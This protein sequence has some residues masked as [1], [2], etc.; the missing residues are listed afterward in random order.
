[1]SRLKVGLIW[2]MC[3]L[4]ANAAYGQMTV[5]VTDIS[6]NQSNLPGSA[7]NPNVNGASG[8]RVNSLGIDR[9]TPARIYAASEWGGLFR[10]TDSGVTWAHIDSHV[11]TA[12]WDVEVDPTNSNRIYVTSFHDGRTTSRAGINVSNDGGATWT[13]PATA[14][15]PTNFCFQPAGQ[16]DSRRAE[17]AAFGISIDPAN[18]NR[19]FIGTNCG[20]AFTTDAG[21]TWTFVDPTPADRARTVWDV[22]V[23]NGGII[24]VCGDDGHLRSTDGGMTWTTSATQPLTAGRCSLTVSPDEAYVLFAVVGRTISESDDGQNWTLN[25]Y[26]NPDVT[27]SPNG[28]GRIPFA[29][30]NQRQGATYDL[31]FGDINLFRGTCTTPAKPAP[32]GARRCT[33][34]TTWPDSDAGAHQDVADIAF[35]Q[36]VAV[37]ACPVLFSSDG[38]V[39]RNTNTTS[40]GCH[41]PAWVQPTVTPHALWNYAFTGVARAGAQPEDLYFG[42]Q[43]TGTFGTLNG[44]ATPVTWTNERCCDGFAVAAEGTRALTTV[45]CFGAATLL[46]RANAGLPPP[47]PGAPPANQI[48][49]VPAGNLRTWEHLPSMQNFG[50]DDYAVATTTGVFVT[51]D[52]GAATITWTQLGA[53]SSPASPCGVQVA[54][55]GGTPTFFVKSGGCDGP[56]GG[57]A[58]EQGTLWRYQGTAAGGTWQQV[59]NP[60]TAGAFGIY[61]VDRN[62]PQRLI[63]SHLGGP[64]GPRM[65]MTWNGGTTWSPIATL[66]T[67]MTGSGTFQYQTQIGASVFT[68]FN[69]YSQPTLVAFDPADPDLIVAGGA[70]SGVFL[71]SNGGTRWQLVTDPI[72]P[73][74][75]G[76]PHIPR[77]YYAHFDHD[78]PGGDI[79]LYLGTRGRGAW[80]LSFKKVAMPEIQVPAAPFFEATCQGTKAVSTLNVCNS[81]AGNLIVSSI[82]SSNPEF[83]IIPP[84][85]GFPVTISHDFCFPF[86]VAFTPTSPG[87]KTATFTIASNDPNF[88][89]VQ[90]TSN[91]S[92]GQP[93][94]VTV[95]ADTGNFGELCANPTKFRDLDVTISNSG[96]CPLIIT[97]VTSSSLEFELAQVLNFPVSVAAGDTVAVPIR[98]HPTSPGAKSA[99]ITFATNDPTTPN[100]VVNVSG[101]SPPSYVCDPPLFAAIDAAVGATFGPSRTGDYTFNGSG[102]VL[103]SFGANRTFGVQAQGEALYF[104]GG[105]GRQEGQLDTAL[106]YRRGI[107]QFGVS[108]SFK[109]AQLR[110]EAS[111]GALTHGTLALDVLLPTVRF[112]IFGARGVHESDV[113]TLS[114]TIG[115]PAPPGQ[116]IIA[117]EQLVHTVDQVGGALQGQLVPNWWLDFHLAWLHRHAPGVGNTA[118]GA[119][120]VSGLVLPNLAVF[121]Q[122]DVNE[123]FIGSHMMGTV[124]FGVTLGRWS[125]PTDYSN[126]VNP[127]GTMIPRVRYERF[128]RIR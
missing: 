16:P 4:A 100:K 82:T 108:G 127:L 116:P 15:P 110:S 40:P 84:S 17:P 62:N 92:V 48:T 50:T 107:W 23:H 63:A 106:L 65:V 99:T 118:G 18:A 85:A 9:S 6:P 57:P 113:V 44:G 124:T 47:P 120:R 121:G 43:D 72:S 36:G 38:G 125:R 68:T 115:P 20:L 75:S 31:W 21:A 80:R 52:I 105:V 58:Q 79:N 1:M 111:A 28:G 53:A 56:F 30:T 119:L 41:T 86:Q 76:R 87:P 74:T 126:P 78:P 114:E 123:S 25:S 70:D 14:T 61:A 45:C 66:D 98:F 102:R 91:V 64:G 95:I 13:H 12:T 8:G 7:T 101:T 26:V 88:P 122:V 77:P 35:A 34:G 51:L 11:P 109:S 27:T 24:D 103:K 3:C 39:Y 73:G 33:A 97:G 55:A 89:S 32:G 29:A 60:A 90:V 94:A 81:S 46:F 49:Q 69:G 93:R 42:N 59:P 112:G 67:M 54:F 128:E 22:V 10:S 19:V 71:S 83:S 117:R 2:G 5:T 104:P 96:S 37:D